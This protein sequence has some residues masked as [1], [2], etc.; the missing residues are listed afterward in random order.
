MRIAFTGTHGGGK[1]VLA[2]ILVEHLNENGKLLKHQLIDNVVTDTAKKMGYDRS[3]LVPYWRKAEL[4]WVS[5]ANQMSA[6]IKAQNFVSPRSPICYAAYSGLADRL[7]QV[8]MRYSAVEFQNRGMQFANP[9]YD[10]CKQYAETYDFIFYI[11]KNSGK[12]E[13]NGKR[14]TDHVEEID[15]YIKQMISDFGL[16]EKVHFIQSDTPQSRL[17]E[18]LEV[19][20]R[21]AM[22]F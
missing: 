20:R 3:S 1:S 11:P 2:E 9:Y 10:V 19:I 15:E 13:N 17:H 7:G 8:D 14:F 16:S 22:R 21:P 18:V 6:Q 4:Q 5:L 12:L